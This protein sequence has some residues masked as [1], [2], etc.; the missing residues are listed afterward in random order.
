MGAALDR[1]AALAAREAADQQILA[2]AGRIHVGRYRRHTKA[3]RSVDV[4][5]YWRSPRDMKNADIV[6]EMNSLTKTMDP[7][8]RER[9]QQLA[10]EVRRRRALG[11][12]KDSDTQALSHPGSSVSHSLA[13][14]AIAGGFTFDRLSQNPVEHGVSVGRPGG[15]SILPAKDRDQAQ[16]QLQDFLSNLP[17]DATTVGGWLDTENN[18]IC[19]DIVDVLSDR[20]KAVELGRKRNQQAVFDLDALEEIDTGGSGDERKY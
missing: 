8:S 13:A 11:Q 2:L 10:N 16:K 12:W 15:S 7:K 9:R 6:S 17:A 18:E 14:A 3:G 19:L 20:R 4:A 5:S 1:L